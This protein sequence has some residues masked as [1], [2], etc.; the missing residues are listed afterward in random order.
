MIQNQGMIG[1]AFVIFPRR[2]QIVAGKLHKILR[3]LYYNILFVLTDFE[4]VLY[5]RINLSNRG[6]A[7]SSTSPQQMFLYDIP[8][9]KLISRHLVFSLIFPLICLKYFKIKFG[10]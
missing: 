9:Y 8:S 2:F 7:V 1:I 4:R 6:T 5:T 3:I 10:R